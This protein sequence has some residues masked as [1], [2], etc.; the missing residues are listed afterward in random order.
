MAMRLSGLMSGMDTESIVQ[1]LVQVRGAKVDKAKKEQT[2]LQWKQDAWKD[3]NTKIKNLQSKYLSTMRFPDAYS[4]KTTTVS[5]S[6]IASVITGEKAV[7]GVQHLEVKSLAKTAYLTGGTVEKREGASS[8]ELSALTKM[9]DLMTFEQDGEGNEISKNLVLKGV[10]D[11]DVNIELTSDTTISDILNK[12]KEKGL[13]ANFDA[14]QQRFFI[15]AKDSGKNG[16]F[17]IEGDD[18]TLKALGLNVV[19]EDSEE[20]GATYIPGKNAEIKLN[21]ATFESNDNV[22]E[23]NGLTFTALSETKEGESVTVTTQQDTDGI[24][25]MIKNFLKEYNTVINEMDKLYNAESAK[26]FEPLTDEEKEAMSESEAE[27]Y[28]Q[29]IK[30]ALLRRDSSLNSISSAMRETMMKGV[31]IDGESMYLADFGIGTLGYFVAPDNEKNAYHIDGDADDAD[32]AGNADKLKGLIASDPDKVINFFTKLSQ[33]LYTEMSNQ[34]KSVEGYRSFGNFYDDKKMKSDYDDYTSKIKD[35][36]ARLADY[37]DS[38]Y[39]KFAKME[40]AMAKMQDN[41]SAITSLIGG[42]S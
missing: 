40:T 13:N 18:T 30:D 4:K 5:N 6:S 22:F 42:G 36:E 9:N 19:D 10:G 25:D 3:L 39:S 31:E 37:E 38:W 15:S 1:Q 33:N 32:T 11:E 12:L 28:E 23:I 2:K 34:S 29:K 8:E 14:K 41:M 20:S 21:G 17:S 16:N 7:N 24:Y 27:K 26:G 35:L